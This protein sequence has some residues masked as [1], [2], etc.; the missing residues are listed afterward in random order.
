MDRGCAATASCPV[1]GGGLSRIDGAILV[2]WFGVAIVGLARSGRFAIGEGEAERRR[3]P[4]IPLL[5]GLAILTVGGGMLAQGLRGVVDRLGVSATLLGNTVIAASV[6]G[7]EVVRVA[8][9]TRRGRG[10]L[11]L[12]NITGTIIHFISFNAGVIALVKPLTFDDASRYLHLPVAVAATWLLCGLLWLRKGLTRVVG[13]ALLG[14]YVA[15]VAAAI[16]VS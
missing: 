16:V 14:L 12:A 6:E 10:D 2:L 3:R 1:L 13:A 15:Y 8:V 11:G 5:G 9:P 7:E 4:L